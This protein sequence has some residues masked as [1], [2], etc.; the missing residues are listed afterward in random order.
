MS[1]L[2]MSEQAR[3]RAY[4]KGF[5]AENGGLEIM[6]EAILLI[7]KTRENFTNEDFSDGPTDLRDAMFALALSYV[8]LEIAEEV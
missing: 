1:N 6:S 3:Q 7:K 5:A 8:A 2:L 4:L